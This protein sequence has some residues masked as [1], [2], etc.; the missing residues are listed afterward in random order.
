V[1]S[2]ASRESGEVVERCPVET[3]AS[4]HG[5]SG[6]RLG[7]A[8]VWVP[9]RAEDRE[10]PQLRSF[11][12]DAC[13]DRWGTT[14]RDRRRDASRGCQREDSQKRAHPARIIYRTRG[15]RSPGPAS[16]TPEGRVPSPAAE[17]NSRGAEDRRE[18]DGWVSARRIRHCV[19]GV[20][21]PWTAPDACG[22]ARTRNLGS[23]VF[24]PT[25]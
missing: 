3:R 24:K 18:R 13:D 1:S 4:Q 16:L 25:G 23:I 6:R 22:R 20:R 10:L 14:Q 11:N 21:F 19:I 5:P 17:F 7:G 15:C 2:V 12:A 8:N 9:G